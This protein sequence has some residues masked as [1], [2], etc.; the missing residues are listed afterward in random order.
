ML[1][2]ER[3]DEILD[4]LGRFRYASFDH[5]V[6]TLLWSTG[7]RMGTAQALDVDDYD[8]KNQRLEAR[9]RPETGT[10]LKNG[11]AGERLIALS[12]ET[13]QV[14][15]DWIA[16][17]RPDVT[18]D[19]GREP[20]VAT[21][22]GRGSKSVIRDAVYRWTRPCQIADCPHGPNP[23]MCE[24][25]DDQRKTYSKCPSARSPHAIRRGSITH[26]LSEDVPETIVSDRMNVS[27]DVLD[28]HY[29]RRS[30]EVKVE[31]RREYLDGV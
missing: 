3:A 2:A 13:C 14:L 1:E 10:R 31:Q 21:S 17:R 20:L 29:D 23:E 11:K 18:D 26:H 12:L 5:L 24:A 15:D 8:P 27:Q 4:F 7:L 28:K 6:L 16:E 25:A 22:H 9:H 30:E 19:Y